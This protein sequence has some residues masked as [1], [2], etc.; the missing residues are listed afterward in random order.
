MM[1]AFVF[2]HRDALHG[3]GHVNWGVEYANGSFNVGAVE[4]PHGAF[5]VSPGR[6]GF[7]TADTRF[8]PA[9][10]RP[11]GY[12][13][14]K[15]VIPSIASPE[16]AWQEVERISQQPYR[17]LGSNCLDDV[18]A[19]LHAYGVAGLPSPH[20]EILPNRW[21]DD[22]AAICISIGLSGE[23]SDDLEH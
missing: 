18:Y 11:L 22:I 23:I 16:S 6:M 10:M 7:W 8:P 1:R 13:A 17:L 9:V 5:V 21:F 15:I 19:I 4:N 2:D 3:V 20:Q 14:Y 12:V